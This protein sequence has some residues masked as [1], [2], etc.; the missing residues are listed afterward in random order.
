MFTSF[1]LIKLKRPCLTTT[2]QF[3]AKFGTTPDELAEGRETISRDAKESKVPLKTVIS[4]KSATAA[5]SN[6]AFSTRMSKSATSAAFPPMPTRSPKPLSQS[7]NQNAPTLTKPSS[8]STSQQT[9]ID[10]DYKKLLTKFYQA[11]DPN[12]VA[13]VDATIEKYKVRAIC[14][15]ITG[16]AL[17]ASNILSQTTFQGKEAEMFCAY[18]K[19]Y[20]QPNA[21][22]EEFESRVKSID[23][24]DYFALLTL[25]LQVYNPSKVGIVENYLLKNKVRY[26]VFT[27]HDLDASLLTQSFLTSL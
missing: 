20:N 13:T 6:A 18:A 26:N 1:L 3:I 9:R 27:L 14:R 15:T 8:T 4:D 24:S 22:N 23:K 12:R 17:T 16:F 2:C 5:S 19:R 11:N 10:V 25:Y 21:L 7:L